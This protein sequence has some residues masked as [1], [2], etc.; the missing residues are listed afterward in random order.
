MRRTLAGAAA[1]VVAAASGVAVA[2]LLAAATRPQAGPLVAVGAAV[3][4]A[5]PTPLKEF[6]V[7]E[8]GTYDKPVLLGSIALVLALFTAVVG[9]LTLRRRWVAVAG[10]AVFG[11]VGVAA[12]LSRPAAEP[13]DAVPALLGAAVAGI[14]LIVLTGRVAA[15]SSSATATPEA[16]ASSPARAGGV[17]RRMTVSVG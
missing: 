14:A 10:A 9:I 12:A 6:A 11:A 15:A 13:F 17:M 16:A 8:L 1:G 7:R 3:I 4:D 5:T 2:E